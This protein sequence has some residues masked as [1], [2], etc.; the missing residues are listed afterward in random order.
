LQAESNG[1]VF[2]L[3]PRVKMASTPAAHGLSSVFSP[4]IID[5]IESGIRL[6]L[7]HN[8][9][10]KEDWR[11]SE[12]MR[13]VWSYCGVSA[14]TRLVRACAS[15]S[16][17]EHVQRDKNCIRDTRRVVGPTPNSLRSGGISTLCRLPW[18]VASNCGNELNDHLLEIDCRTKSY[19]AVAALPA[20]RIHVALTTLHDE[21]QLRQKAF[22]A[23]WRSLD[24]CP[25]HAVVEE[26]VW[27]RGAT[28]GGRAA[29]LR[30]RSSS[31]PS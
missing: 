18:S 27:R 5:V 28:S 2:V 7:F 24:L 6:H 30:S 16:I 13:R 3:E 20:P 4:I 14:S 31:R 10:K 8:I 29:G 11:H 1:V 26:E 15:N 19:A 23:I 22:L 9:C 25:N 17:H 12:S 21:S